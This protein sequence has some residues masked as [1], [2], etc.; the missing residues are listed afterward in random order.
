MNVAIVQ[1]GSTDNKSKS[2]SFSDIETSLNEYVSPHSL[3]RIVKKVKCS[4][5]RR[6]KISSEGIPQAYAIN[7]TNLCAHLMP[8]S[9]HSFYD[10]LRG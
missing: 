1:G 4:K 10:V 5:E 6:G 8:I 3:E 7:M 2:L 9:I